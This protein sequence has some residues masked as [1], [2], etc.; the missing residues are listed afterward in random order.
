[1]NAQQGFSTLDTEMNGTTRPSADV[2]FQRYLTRRLSTKKTIYGAYVRQAYD[3]GKIDE[4]QVAKL[5]KFLE[6]PYFPQDYPLVERLFLDMA[7]DQSIR[8]PDGIAASR[9]EIDLL[10]HVSEWAV[11]R[12]MPDEVAQA[13]RKR[14]LRT[15]VPQEHEAILELQNE[16]SIDV[17]KILK[18]PYKPDLRHMPAETFYLF[19]EDGLRVAWEKTRKNRKLSGKETFDE[20][21][22]HYSQNRLLEELLRKDTD[23]PETIH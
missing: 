10:K 1:M 9:E 19:S 13:I 21:L 2:L 4:E 12:L 6:A 8:H 3:A 23:T 15:L 7:H 22:L 14:V 20:T 16:L 11:L 5:C 17:E 18:H